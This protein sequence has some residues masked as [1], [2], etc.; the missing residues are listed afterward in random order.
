M[1]QQPETDQLQ[2]FHE[3]LSQW[4]SSQGFWFQLRYSTSGKGMKGAFAFHF[5]RLVA[6]IAMFLLIAAAGVWV[7][8]VNKA[9]MTSYREDFRAALKERLGAKEIE[10]KGLERRKGQFSI[11]RLTMSGTEGTFF[12]GLDLR[13]LKCRKTLIE[14]LFEE[15]WDPGLITISRAELGLRAGS[16]SLEA[17]K[18]IADTYFQ[19]TG[20]FNLKSIVVNDMSLRWGY[21]ERTRGSITGSK[22]RAERLPE[23][24]RLRFR[25]GTFSQNWLKRLEIV[26][27]DIAFGRKGVIFER[28]LFRK[29]QG[30]VSF[31]DLEV[32]AGDRPEITGTMRLRKIDVSALLPMSV[33]N[34]VDGTLSAEF[35]VFGS[36]NS[37]EGVGFEGDVVLEGEDSIVIR[38]RIPLLR[39]L[40]VVDAVNT[41]RRVNFQKGFFRMKTHDGRLDI[42][43]ANLNAGDMM[44]LKGS[45]AVRLPTFEESQRFAESNSSVDSIGILNDDEF[46]FTLERAA[47]QSEGSE[48][49]G[50][51][52][53]G[54][55]SL[56]DKLGL[57]VE[58]RTLEEKTAEQLSR[59]LH[60]EGGFEISLPKEVI[61]KAPRLAEAYPLRDPTGRVLM[62]VPLEGTLY[63]LTLKQ[64]DE[65]YKLGAR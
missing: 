6:R 40:S 3:R 30:Y 38:D 49:M 35:Q 1:D 48:R 65:I 14:V 17:A 53:A 52:E 42:T 21:S 11:S 59:S 63:D 12:T 23:G 55:D 8:L 37:T 50:F 60:Y 22:M 57:N 41:Y 43:G 56:F 58:T 39:A 4:V 5:F 62:R 51:G 32:K 33:R 7:Y 44:N 47:E 18:S 34:F 2:N 45:L 54:E 13:S 27:L 46:D 64:A 25:G 9:D 36:T 26:E 15:E 19:N 31:I 61:E 28:A 10:V 29:G 24:W 16:D 20:G